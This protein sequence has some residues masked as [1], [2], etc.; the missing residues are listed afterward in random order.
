MKKSLLVNSVPPISVYVYT[1]VNKMVGSCKENGGGG[2]ATKDVA[3]KI[4]YGKKK[5][6]TPLEMV[7]WC[8]SRFENN[9][10][11]AVRGEDER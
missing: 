8:F 4:V 3:K 2:N 11:K 5:R 9:E 7:G 1:R 6:K 10:D